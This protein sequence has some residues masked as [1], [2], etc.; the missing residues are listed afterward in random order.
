MPFDEYMAQCLYDAE[1]GYFTTGGVRPGMG[2]DFV[3]SPEVSP[4]FGRLI[5]RWATG[6]AGDSDAVLVEIGSGTGSLLAPLVE[7]AA[8]SF[9]SVHAVEVSESAREVTSARVPGSV[10]VADLDD[11][12]S[13]G[14]AVAIVN[15]VL[16]NLPAKLVERIDGLWIEHHV[17]ARGE[18]LLL[19][20]FPAK[21]ELAAWCDQRLV[22]APDRTLLTAQI[23]VEEWISRMVEHFDRV[24]ACI[25]DYGGDTETLSGR[26]R[27]DVVRTYRRQRAG[28]DALAEPGATDITVDVN[29]D[30]V[31]MVV[32]ELGGSVMVTDQASFLDSY[33]A[34]AAVRDLVDRSHALARS[35]EVMGQLKARSDATDIKAL[36]DPAGFGGF[37]VFLI[38]AGT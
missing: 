20:A 23:A 14:H 26:R 16:D 2:S 15:E 28:F 13:G 24:D 29:A 8:G 1:D 6:V 9:A 35:S 5:G 17:V 38:S 22:G 32:E 7:E 11:I 12:P 33:G 37:S 25:I 18:A 19:E 4:W 30:V 10:V 3:T 31:R 27:T 36:V 34:G 21:A